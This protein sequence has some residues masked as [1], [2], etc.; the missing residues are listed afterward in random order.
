M[1]QTDMITFLA[2]LSKLAVARREKLSKECMAIYFDD[3]SDLPL[4][5]VLE[6]MVWARKN[7]THFPYIPELRRYIEGDPQTH[8]ENAWSTLVVT[9]REYKSFC[10]RTS[11][12][13]AHIQ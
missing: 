11:P 7:L 1:E 10:P 6:A 12:F 8:A 9:A 2:E 4:E 3:L 5:T 13:H